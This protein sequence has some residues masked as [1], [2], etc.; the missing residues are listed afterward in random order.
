MFD[1]LYDFGDFFID[2]FKYIVSSPCGYSLLFL[3]LLTAVA[4]LFWSMTGGF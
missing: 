1:L 2:C 3:L 4:E